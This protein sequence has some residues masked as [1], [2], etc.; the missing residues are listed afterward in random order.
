MAVFRSTSI[1]LNRSACDQGGQGLFFRKRGSGEMGVC[2]GGKEVCYF[3][4]TK[5]FNEMSSTSSVSVRPRISELQ[6]Q[7]F[8]HFLIEPL[9]YI[10]SGVLTIQY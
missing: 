8:I 6:Y 7:V 2:C 3:L 4:F 10:L 5:F 1:K 9:S